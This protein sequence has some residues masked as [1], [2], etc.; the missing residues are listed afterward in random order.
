MSRF[1]VKNYKCLADVE[2]PLTPIHVL[3]GPNDAGKTS[4]LEAMAALHASSQVPLPQAFSGPWTGQE[5]VFAGR[6]SEPVELW[7]QW[8]EDASDISQ[9]SATAVRYGFATSFPL[10]GRGCT[11]QGDWIEVEGTPKPLSGPGRWDRTAVCQWNHGQIPPTDPAAAHLARVSKLLRPARR[12]AFDPKFMALPAVIDPQ[13]KFRMDA[14]GFG[15]PTLLLDI[16]SHDPNRFL[17]L[18]SRFCEFFPQFRSVR[19]QTE[20]AMVRQ[21]DPGSETHTMGRG[22]GHG[23]YFDTTSGQT[24]RAQHASDGV[25]LFLGFLAIAHLPE[26]PNLLLIEEPENGIYPKRLDQ[27]IRL[28]KQL[29]RQPEGPRFPQIVFTTHSPFVL[30]FFE[31]E[32]ATFLTRDPENPEAGVRARPLR[33]APQIRELL[34][35][36]EFYLGE[37][38]YNYGEEELFGESAARRGD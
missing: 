5:L 6:S 7:G 31:P 12:Y 29:V 13:R 3:I 24:I 26:P 18:R 33:D 11:T 28:L 21:Y 30:S 14:D 36:G 8:E 32:E 4:A 35:G 9:G 1:G 2:F 20:N 10:Q 16:L 17:A 15:L 25:I 38:W 37:L 22:V 27:V 23:I 19:L 34:G